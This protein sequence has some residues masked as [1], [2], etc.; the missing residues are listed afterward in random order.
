LDWH[1]R[2]TLDPAVLVGKPCIK[3]T[4]VS[5]ELVVDSLAAGW[6]YDEILESWDHL[7]RDDILACLAYAGD[8]LKMEFVHPPEE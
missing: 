7:T 1:E 5:V 3:G 6:S 2:I 4:R 8:V